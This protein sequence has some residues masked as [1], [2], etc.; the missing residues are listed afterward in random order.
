MSDQTTTRPWYP[1]PISAV[2]H[3]EPVPRRIRA[4]LT[5]SSDVFISLAE[6]TRIANSAGADLFVHCLPHPNVGAKVVALYY[7]VGGTVRALV[8]LASSR[9]LEELG[10]LVVASGLPLF[11]LGNGNI[12]NFSLLKANRPAVLY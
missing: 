6:R 5:R 3:L 2:D 1:G 12:V 7:R 9:D 4:E 8:T 11:V 10:P